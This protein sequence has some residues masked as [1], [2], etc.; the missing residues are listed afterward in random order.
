MK[1]GKF[2]I[3]LVHSCSWVKSSQIEQ[4][5]STLRPIDAPPQVAG[6]ARVLSTPL[7]T[8]LPNCYRT[9]EL[10]VPVIQMTLQVIQQNYCSVVGE[11]GEAFV[12]S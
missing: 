10:E 3:H 5:S 7:D 2:F 8:S 12:S 1:T 4:K 11:T 9:R 6:S